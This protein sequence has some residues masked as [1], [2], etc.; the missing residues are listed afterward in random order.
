MATTQL[1]LCLQL[2][3]HVHYSFG[4]T[5]PFIMVL[6]ITLDAPTVES[7]LCLAQVED[8]HQNSP[9]SRLL[10]C[11]AGLDSEE[12]LHI[13]ADASA[14]QTPLLQAV[15]SEK[16]RH[17]VNER[18]QASWRHNVSGEHHLCPCTSAHAAPQIASA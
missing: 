11:L 13:C 9:A 18:E 4:I 8:P 2:C 12:V 15:A 16:A 5:V 6:I 14:L 3:R 1:R 17:L 10:Q 7:W